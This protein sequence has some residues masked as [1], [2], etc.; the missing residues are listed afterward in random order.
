[1]KKLIIAAFCLFFSVPAMAAG[2]TNWFTISHI[3]HG[4][5]ETSV[6]VSSSSGKF[7][8]YPDGTVENLDSCSSSDAYGFAE[9][10]LDST[11]QWPTGVKDLIKL[12]TLAYTAGWQV[13]LYLNGCNGA[14]PRPHARAIE[15]KK[16]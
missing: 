13:R 2:W 6:G 9:V 16:P 10:N 1:M 14:T 11:N 8:I 7:F 12:A 5:S 15:I 4:I 3:G